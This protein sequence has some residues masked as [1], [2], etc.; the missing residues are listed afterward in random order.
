MS[1][2]H[3]HPHFSYYTDDDGALKPTAHSK[4]TNKK[5]KLKL[6]INI[7]MESAGVDLDWTLVPPWKS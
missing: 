3:P 1:N 7:L 4:K 2:P 5:I 6:L